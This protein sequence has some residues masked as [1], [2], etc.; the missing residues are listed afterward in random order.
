MFDLHCH[1]LPAIDDGAQDLQQAIALIQASITQGVTHI[2]ATPHI[3]LGRFDNSITTI[4]TAFAQLQA[5][6]SQQQLS[7]NL[8]FAAEVHICPEI[9]L[10]AQ[11]QTLPMLGQWQ[12][13]P[14]LLLELPNDH[15]PPGTDKLI[16]WL[17]AQG[18]RVMIAHPERY[19]AFQ[20]QPELLQQFA[21]FGCLFQVTTGALLGEMGSRSQQY[22]QQWLQQDIFTIM[23]T[24][25]HNLQRRAPN[26]QRAFNW[27]SQ[28]VDAQL[29]QQLA[30]A[31]PQTIAAQHFS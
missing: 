9:M 30:I 19:K 21:H 6:I 31:N 10:L 25:A 3:R 24:D 11:Q 18:I 8:A 13:Q 16:K 26:M 4:K 23:A 1:V 22:A 5:E 20:K 17:A 15:I 29:A 7:I 28:H 27:V 14:L 12:G 2:V